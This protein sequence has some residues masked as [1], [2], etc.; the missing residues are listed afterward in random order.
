MHV[1]PAEVVRAEAVLLRSTLAMH[2]NAVGRGIP[3]PPATVLAAAAEVDALLLG[4]LLLPAGPVALS[5]ISGLHDLPWGLLPTLRERSFALAPSFAL[6][7]RCRSTPTQRPD[8]VVCVA[9]PDVPLADEEAARVLRCYPDGQ[10]LG[11][12]HAVVADVARAIGGADVAHL[13]CHGRFSSDNPMFSSLLMA[14]GRMFV[15]DLERVSPAPRVVVLSACHAGSHATPA[16][17]EV[18]GLTASLLARGPRSVVAAT[19]PIPDTLSTLALMT[20]LH[21]GLAA[22]AGAGDALVEVRREDPVVG[23]AFACYGAA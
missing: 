20:T 15:Y 12:A 13:V 14:D 2:L 3:R 21:T 4:P 23:G 10:L 22:G 16:G 17:R 7:R 1:G 9:G 19:V 18:L 5:P 6:W 8:N 11:G